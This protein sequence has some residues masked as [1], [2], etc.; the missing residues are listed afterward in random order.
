MYLF[1]SVTHLSFNFVSFKNLMGN[2][3][4][5]AGI[6]QNQSALADAIIEV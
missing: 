5:S 1:L 2:K 4:S 3:S 6:L